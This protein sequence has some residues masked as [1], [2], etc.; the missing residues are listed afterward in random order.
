[1]CGW[2]AVNDRFAPQVTGQC[3]QNLTAGVWLSFQEPGRCA[4]EAEIGH[5]GCTWRPKAERGPK[6]YGRSPHPPALLSRR[7]A[8]L[9]ITAG[10]AE[11]DR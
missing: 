2:G 4:L 6:G 5:K 8:V 11:L 3:W 7:T 1:M 10:K 9:E